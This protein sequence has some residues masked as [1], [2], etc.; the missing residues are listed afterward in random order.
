[1]ARFFDPDELDRIER[2]SAQQRQRAVYASAVTQQQVQQVSAF[3]ATYPFA[4]PGVVVPAALSGMSPDEPAAKALAQA[5]V[6]QR[7]NSG[8]G[9]HSFGDVIKG[10]AKAVKS[11]LGDAVNVGQGVIRGAF[12]GLDAGGQAAQGMFREVLDNGYQFGDSERAVAQTDLA[13]GH[14]QIQQQGGYAGLLTGKTDVDYGSGFFV[15]GE[16]ARD[17][18]RRKQT[19]TDIRIDGKLPS[20]GRWTAAQILPPGTKQYNIV[21]GLVDAGVVLAGDPSTY[22][23]GSIT[24]A[25][26][27]DRLFAETTPSRVGKALGRGKN[28]PRD[29][30]AVTD[31]GLERIAAGL[32]DGDTR[33]TI[34]PER[35]GEW[36]LSGKGQAVVSK[37]VETTDPVVLR[38]TFGTNIDTDTLVKL[39]DSRTA[40][41][42]YDIL[43]PQLGVDIREKIPL[44]G[45]IKA[46]V[47]RGLENVRWAQQMP[48]QHVDLHDADDAVSN[49]DRFLVNAKAGGDVR[50]SAVR[51]MMRAGSVTERYKVLTE[52]IETVSNRFLDDALEGAGDAYGRAQARG[53]VR[54]LTGMVI[55]WHEDMRKYFVN[56]I[57]DNYPLPGTVIEGEVKALPSPH[58]IGEY[59]NRAMPLPD[60]RDIRRAT[61]VLAPVIDNKYFKGSTTLGDFVSGQIFKRWVLL[62]PAYT[63][64]VIGEEQIRLAA[65]GK[66]GMFVHPLSHLAIAVSG[67]ST[68]RTA[69]ALNR[70]PGQRTGRLETD[71]LGDNLAESEQ[72]IESLNKGLRDY[73]DPALVQTPNWLTY[74]RK[75]AEFAD[76]WAD[77][78]AELYDN[79]VA[80]RVAHGG[81]YNGDS[82]NG[83]VARPGLDGIKD[84]FFDGAGQG[85]RKELAEGPDKE[86]LNTRE[87]ADAYI[88]SVLDRVNIK[89]GGDPN[90]LSVVESGRFGDERVFEP[91]AVGKDGTRKHQKGT[92]A[93]LGDLARRAEDGIGPEKVKGQQLVHGRLT[94]GNRALASYDRATDHAFSYLMTRPTNF[95]SRS[96]AFR[97]FYYQRAEE[98]VGFMSREAQAAAITAAREAGVDKA[99]I[100][101]MQDAARRG[102]GDLDVEQAD[103]LAKGYG[104]DETKKLLYDMHERSQFFDITRLLFPFGEAWKEVMTTWARIGKDNPVMLRRAGLLVEGARDADLDGD[105][106]GFFYE[107]EM[108]G[109]EMFSIPLVGDLAETFAGLPDG[110]VSFEATAKGANVFSQSVYPGFGPVVQLPASKL[111]PEDAD[112]DFVRGLVTPFGATDTSGGILESFLP[113]WAKKVLT[114]YAPHGEAQERALANAT[115]EAMRVLVS[116]GD[117]GNSR[118]EQERLLGDAR[119][120][121]SRLFL[122]RALAQSTAPSAPMWEIA[123]KT[124]DGDFITTF[125]LSQEYRKMQEEDYRTATSRFVAKFGEGAFLSTIGKSAGPSVS[126]EAYEFSRE[127]PEA[128]RAYKD[129][130]GY[131]VGKAS[132]GLDLTAFQRQFDTGE[133]EVRNPEEARQMADQRLGT[134]IYMTAKSKVGDKPTPAQEE[135]L[136]QVKDLVGQEYPGYVAAPPDLAKTPKLIKQALEAADND[137]IGATDA[138]QG[139]KLYARARAK[140]IESARA[141]GLETFERSP[142]AAGI[143]EWLRSVATLIES[144]HPDFANVYDNLLSRELP[145]DEKAAA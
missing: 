55:D 40:E 131:F 122:V 12:M 66:T 8:F 113:A 67:D 42:V 22:V 84:W 47:R 144:E 132:D 72:G 100:K 32:I 110:S 65:S 75:D 19:S 86:W 48:G 27:A 92:R 112:F 94:A 7:G 95:L 128:A 139:V 13:A 104:L 37:L 28:G 80:K 50:D 25:R 143:R 109:E 53:K 18:G 87:G 2:F 136:R 41:D 77:E 78:L 93:L 46:T 39:A 120:S 5:E 145:D 97:Q 63:V 117:Y 129:V 57:G 3:A 31:H 118:E 20:I 24:K 61:S 9:W 16:V 98:L 114:G 83:G 123:A 15:G 138:G 101:R 38:K 137:V 89:T 36:L 124:K 4:R 116:T 90:L 70:L 34:L 81:L 49:L 126:T 60:A 119:K 103:I 76:A 133:R 105:G 127:N 17:A 69:K 45:A 64:R 68:S 14:R 21:S 106:Q 74:G 111:L 35:V 73:M 10:G 130:Y 141:M 108:T 115:T 26:K 62:R 88:D 99:A 134:M 142:K 140:A 107:D 71:L 135:W 79:A 85:F 82:V 102:S 56:Q 51:S 33:K 59:I 96:P 23:G 121:A 1:M 30:F 58:L 6:K 125:A 54:G 11:G 43:G 52:T 44:P 29:A 91:V